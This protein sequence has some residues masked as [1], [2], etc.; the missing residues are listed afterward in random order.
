MSLEAR[1][2]RYVLGAVKTQLETAIP[3]ALEDIGSDGGLCP[4]KPTGIDATQEIER[5]SRRPRIK[6][7]AEGMNPY[8]HWLTP[9]IDI[10]IPLL[11]LVIAHESDDPETADQMIHEYTRAIEIAL[12]R[13]WQ[14]VTGLTLLR[15]DET[16]VAPLD[17]DTPRIRQGAVR[18]TATLRTNRVES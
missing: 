12:N 13:T 6:L 18:A 10:A 4:T 7:M 15:V 5:E 11:V 8:E 1:H 9:Q 14:N 2:V 3:T 16:G 17:P